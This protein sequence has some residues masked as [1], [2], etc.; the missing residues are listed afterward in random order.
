[1]QNEDVEVFSVELPE[2]IVLQGLSMC[3]HKS[4]EEVEDEFNE[5]IFN[6]GLPNSMDEIVYKY[7]FFCKIK[8][9]AI[10]I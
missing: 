6:I 7:L 8:G 2:E 10:T 5:W 4:K 9:E 1:M 3:P